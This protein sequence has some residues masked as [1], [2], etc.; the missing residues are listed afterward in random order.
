MANFLI[1]TKPTTYS[2][3]CFGVSRWRLLFD[4]FPAKLRISVAIL[5]Y[6]CNRYACLEAC[7]KKCLSRGIFSY[8]TKIRKGERRMK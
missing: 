8:V 7:T 2:D 5:Y 3:F 6:L 4:I 1:A